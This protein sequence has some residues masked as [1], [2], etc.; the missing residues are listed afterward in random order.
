MIDWVFLGS[1]WPIFA[2]GLTSGLAIVVW[3]IRAESRSKANEVTAKEAMV[4][5]HK[6]T[7][8][9]SLFKERVAQEYATATTLLAVREE[10]GGAINRLSDR[11][12]RILEARKT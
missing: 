2:F 9:L 5:A 12:D 7:E 1:L 3:A 6:T 4:V 10:I 8:D 11:I